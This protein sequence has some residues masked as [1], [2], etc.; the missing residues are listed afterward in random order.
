MYII[1]V[2]PLTLLPPN[3]PQILSY[4]FDPVRGKTPLEEGSS[5][6]RVPQERAMPHSENH[7]SQAGRTSNGAGSA[8]PKG[9]IVEVEINKRKV[10]AV[11][12]SSS[13]LEK[14]KL[15][16]KKVDFRIKK[17][18]KVLFKEPQISDYQLKLAVWLARYYYAPL[19]YTL[20]TILPP[21]KKK[22]KYL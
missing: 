16:L 19:G 7:A 6:D 13:S 22:K 20:K 14:E 5:A 3:V 4:F 10:R 8:L 15:A 17:I 11:V 9:A 18:N 2:I 1:E 12:I 21:K